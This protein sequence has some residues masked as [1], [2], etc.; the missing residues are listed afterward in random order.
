MKLRTIQARIPENL[1]NNIEE[2]VEEGLYATTSEAL[3]DAL[4]RTFAEQ[5]REFLRNLA[6]KHG[7]TKE[8][9]LKEWEKI[10]HGK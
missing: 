1:Y 2:M 8:D 5:N 10:R 7:V 4:R 6:K 9:M 3:R